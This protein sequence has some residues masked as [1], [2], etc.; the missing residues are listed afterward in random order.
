MA[1]IIGINGS[2]RLSKNSANLLD[3]ALEGAKENGCEVQKYDLI[4]L[5]FS[6]CV[7]CF[8]CKLLGSPGFGKCAVNDDLK[9]VLSEI[10]SSNGLIVSA[11]IYFGNVPGMVRNFFERLWFPGYTY[12][13][14]GKI[15]YTK[16]VPVRLIFDMNV[17]DDKVYNDLYENYKSI[18]G[19][20]LGETEYYAVPYTLQ[21]DDYSKYASAVFNEE[22]R[23]QRH[24]EVFPKELA[25]AKEIGSALAA[26]YK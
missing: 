19:N 26:L 2:P 15:A 5:K 16:R 20:I 10:L 11:P 7:S 1:K 25:R 12:S 23:K 17:P 13:P 8:A 18:C 24:K 4:K 21:F 9:P 14:D 22:D 6:G 3:A